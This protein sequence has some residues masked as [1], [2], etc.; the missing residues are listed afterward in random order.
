MSRVNSK[1]YVIFFSKGRKV[2]KNRLLTLRKNNYLSQKEFANRTGVAYGTYQAY[3]YG[4]Q[5]PKF[6]YL[7]KVAEIFGVPMSFFID[8]KVSLVASVVS[9][10]ESV[11]SGVVSRPKSV[12]SPPKISSNIQKPQTILVPVYDEVVASAGSGRFNEDFKAFS[13][14]FD[15]AH[16]KRLFA[17]ANVDNLAI[18]RAMGDS[19][20][21]TLPPNARLL[22][23]FRTEFKEGQIVACRL[24]DELFVKR[25]HKQPRL[26]LVSD[27]EKF[28]PIELGGKDYEL[29]GVIV[30]FIKAFD[31]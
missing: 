8:D 22:L 16:L 7:E 4:T 23:Q 11:V 26:R 19:M 13:V 3:E 21:P 29:I 25:L 2:L 17:L 27:N 20:T 10:N 31:F 28:E 18:I 1:I 14:E 5:S 6:D 24:D 12:V 15:K 9:Q 30:G